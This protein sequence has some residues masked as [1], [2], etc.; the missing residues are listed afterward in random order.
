MS[1]RIISKALTALSVAA[2]L[3]ACWWSLRLAWADAL[4]REN[5]RASVSK[6]AQID[7]GNA[8]Y[9]AW[10][11]EIQEHDGD[12]PSTELEIASKLNP[13]ESRVW[14]RRGLRAESEGD[15]AKA[16]RLLLH[17]AALDKLYTPRWTLANYYV[18]R[19]D[20][21]RF[22]VWA[23]QALEMGYGDLSPIFRLCWTA[24][25]D[26]VAIFSRGVPRR[27][28]VLAKYLAFLTREDRLEAAA[29]VAQ[30]L[31]ADA[32]PEDAPAA[33]SYCDRLLDRKM[34]SE[35]VAVWNGLA[36]HRAISYAALEPQRGAILTN[37]DFRNEPLQQGFDWKVPLEP[38]ISVARAES[39]LRFRLTGKQPEH[40]DLLWQD[41]PLAAG[42]RYVFRFEYRSPE[43]KGG[44][45][46]RVGE[47]ARSGELTATDWTETAI[48]FDARDATL[49]RLKLV[50]NRE[51]GAVRSEGDIW[52]R[53]AS[54][55]LA[56]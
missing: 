14:I 32:R 28:D 11:A 9:H 30:A 33:L 38:E 53:N 27:R 54:I 22:W 29:P 10:L 36:Q 8:S 26:P 49:A 25:Q 20:A 6:A 17:A 15:L 39:G 34:A 3:G 7:S 35:A 52:I 19:G 47:L 42:M 45:R 16:E 41:V 48:A 21:E 4:F 2:L 46:W 55:A 23:R 51:P 40:C 1:A 56:R 18:R 43:G 37:G 24:S 44:V 5:T 31:L 50:Y 12:D 13:R